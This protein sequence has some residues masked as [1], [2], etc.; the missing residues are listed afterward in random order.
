MSRVLRTRIR[1][2][3]AVVHDCRDSQGNRVK[4]AALSNTRC[5]HCNTYIVYI[6][7]NTPKKLPKTRRKKHVARSRHPKQM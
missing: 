5:R 3:R 6:W 1:P 2:F 4:R 7:D